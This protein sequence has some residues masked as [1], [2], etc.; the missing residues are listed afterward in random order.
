MPARKRTAPSRSQKIELPEI[1]LLP[2]PIVCLGLVLLAAFI[3]N[4]SASGK[5]SPNPAITVQAAS[6]TTPV[7]ASPTAANPTVTARITTAAPTTA[8]VATVKTVTTAQTAAVTLTVAATTGA[9]SGVLPSATPAASPARTVKAGTTAGNGIRLTKTEGE[10][11]FD[12][13]VSPGHIGDNTYSLLLSENG[14]QAVT[15][16][17][18]VRLS[19]TSLDMDMGIATLDLQPA[20]PDQPGLYAGLD[21]KLQMLSMFGKYNIAALVQRPG[22]GDVTTSFQVMVTGG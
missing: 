5:P 8:T 13:L 19:V 22:K 12:L 11:K 17:S 21:S 4:N 3:N 6:L 10:L 2:L 18:L 20:G 7:P 9:E 15:D 1:I 14:N 16:A